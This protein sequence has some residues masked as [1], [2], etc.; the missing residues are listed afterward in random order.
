M[1]VKIKKEKM[2]NSFKKSSSNVALKIVSNELIQNQA[3]INLK[4]PGESVEEHVKLIHNLAKEYKG[5]GRVVG[6]SFGEDPKTG[7]AIPSKVRNFTIGDVEANI[8]FYNEIKDD[9][10]RNIYM[11]LCV[12]K[13]DLA[14]T[15][16][17]SIKEIVAVLGLVV[18]F[19]DDDAINYKNRLPITPSFVLETSKDRFQ[20]FYIFNK[21][22]SPVKAK[23]IAELLYQYSGCDHGTKDICHVWRMPGTLNWPNKKKVNAGRPEEPQIVK[24]AKPWDGNKVNPDELLKVLKKSDDTQVK[25]DEKSQ[26]QSSDGGKL[27]FKLTPQDEKSIEKMI[28]QEGKVFKNL[29]NKGD[30]SKYGDD[31]SKA[32]YALMMILAFYTVCNTE[33]MER[34]FSCSK[35]GQRKK[36]KKRKDYRK[37]T[38]TKAIVNCNK[39]YDPENGEKN[40]CPL[41]VKFNKQGTPGIIPGLVTKMFY[42]SRIGTLLY[43]HSSFYRYKTGKWELVSDEK[44]ASEISKMILAGRFGDEVIRSPIV[45]DILKQVRRTLIK[46]EGFIFNPDYQLFNFINGVFELKTEEFRKHDSRDYQSQQFPF[47]FDSEAKCK[48]WL[49]FLSE[50]WLHEDTIK[51]LQEWFGY[52]LIPIIMIEKCLYLVGDGAN[53]K[54]VILEV[55]NALLG[56]VSSLSIKDMSDRFKLEQLEGKLANICTDTETKDLGELFKRIVSGEKITA[57]RKNK[58]AFD[59]RPVA[60]LFFS[61]NHLITTRDKSDGLS[62]RFDIIEFKRKFSDEE[63]DKS[64]KFK[65]IKA[66]LPGVFNWA[67]EGLIRLKSNNWIFTHSVEM[68]A[69]HDEFKLSLNP[70]KQFIDEMCLLDDVTSKKGEL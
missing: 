66:E 63:A 22:I 14:A 47:H 53:G 4:K 58:P 29:F 48:L 61:A 31:H 42:D 15:S 37:R 65:I 8:D 38:I 6:A 57:E 21:P 34:I 1:V 46:D 16:K 13:N 36:W 41:W 25:K 2:K 43:T 20:A 62:R 9:K 17:G 12:F 70:V 11:P 32:D 54:S 52:S 67:L 59:F 40:N 5:N 45:D 10:H 28:E 69:V 56:D 7:E 39:V 18:D 49:K 24:Y 64:L 44:I 23:K 26:P 3:N 55:L 27:D 51:R 68:K 30:I 35:L 19:D 33:Q 50:L 60:K